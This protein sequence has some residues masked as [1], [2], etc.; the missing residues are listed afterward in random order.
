ML[1]F[2]A[3]GAFKFYW[4]NFF[5]RAAGR[6]AVTMAVSLAVG[7]ITGHAVQG[8]EAA[9]GAFSVG[10]GSFHEVRK[11]RIAPML[12]ASVGMCFSSWIGTIAGNSV[13][14]V[15]LV[16]ALGGIV[17]AM[18]SALS[19][20]VSYVGLQCVVW[21]VISSA[22]PASGI[23]A[24]QRGS[25]VLAGGLL[26]TLMVVTLWR[27]EHTVTPAAGGTGH[28][29]SEPLGVIRQA[30]T[31]NRQISFYVL[32]AALTL[33]IS[34]AVWHWRALPNGYW[35]PMTAGIVMKPDFR[36][37]MQRGIARITGTL[38]G[39]AL[40]TMFVAALRPGPWIMTGLVVLFAWL[41]YCFLYVNYAAYAACLTAY[42]VFILTFAGLPGME[43]VYLRALNTVIGGSIALAL[44][45]LFSLFETRVGAELPIYK[46]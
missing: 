20:G 27:I 15:I 37:T 30:L 36:Q 24:L 4:A 8:M 23:H 11:S 40:A 35:I 3:E 41:A 1:Q 16:A 33:S 45:M 17:Y 2:L 21:M 14:G 46:N 10:F 44:T 22:Y 38:I 13:P 43:V 5:P 42:V 32:R 39:A 12:Y 28:D 29:D 18:L 31:T 19:P 25:L 26:Q 6:C 7:L 9:A 34:A